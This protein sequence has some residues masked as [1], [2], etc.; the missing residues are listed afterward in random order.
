MSFG[1]DRSRLCR[2]EITRSDTVHL[3][4]IACPFRRQ[5]AG[6]HLQ[7]AFG[8]GISAHR[9][10]SHFAHHRTHIDNFSGAFFNHGRSHRLRHNERPG[11]VDIQYLLEI[12][13]GHFHSGDTFDNSGIVY[14]NIHIA[15]FFCD[16]GDIFDNLVFFGY[17]EQ[18][19]V[20]LDPVGSIFGNSVIQFFFRQVVN[21]QFSTGMSQ[22]FSDR[23]S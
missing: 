16:F 20:S 8:S 4:V 19:A 9:V 15:H 13:N 5:V 1:A 11:Q 10:A 12:G 22:S 14:Q 18:I 23:H 3:D 2:S 7:S 21:H 17:V 6:K